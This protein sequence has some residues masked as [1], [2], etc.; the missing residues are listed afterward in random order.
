VCEPARVLRRQ[1][2]YNP[3]EKRSTYNS[4][5]ALSLGDLGCLCA[6]ATV[7]LT[8]FTATVTCSEPDPQQ[9]VAVGYRPRHSLALYQ[10]KCI[11][12]KPVEIGGDKFK[13][14][15]SGATAEDNGGNMHARGFHA[16]TLESGD[17]V[18]ASMQS[19][20]RLQKD[21]GSNCE[22]SGHREFPK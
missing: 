15:V 16:V 18:T 22:D 19:S 20:Q 21:G 9:V 3:A 4:F 14:G 1:Q 13:D 10:Q 17:K 6:T 8:E 7:A 11:W 2:D 5:R 12:T